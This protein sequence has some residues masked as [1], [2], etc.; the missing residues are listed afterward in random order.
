MRIKQQELKGVVVMALLCSSP[1]TTL[2]PLHP[3]KQNIKTSPAGI[4]R[5]PYSCFT[6]LKWFDEEVWEETRI[7]ILGRLLEKCCVVAKC[8][9]ELRHGAGMNHIFTST[10]I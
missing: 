7:L 2:P 6:R 10:P 8:T 5:Q 1:P 3:T 9:M 4:S